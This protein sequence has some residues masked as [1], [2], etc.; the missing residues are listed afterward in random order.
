MVRVADGGGSSGQASSLS[1]FVQQAVFKDSG[2]SS[3]VR[4]WLGITTAVTGD[5]N[6]SDNQWKEAVILRWWMV[7]WIWVIFAA[8]EDKEGWGLVSGGWRGWLLC[9]PMVND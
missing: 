5:H 3:F 7:P 1:V 9:W 8:V 4:Q 6:D 2:R